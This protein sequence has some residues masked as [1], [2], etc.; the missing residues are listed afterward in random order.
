VLRVADIVSVHVSGT[1]QNVNLIGAEQFAEMKKDAILINL[2]RGYVVDIDALAEN[3]RS[4]KLKGAA[5]DVFPVEPDSGEM[6]QSPL[7]GLPNTVLTPHIAGSTQEAQKEISGFV[8][9]KMINYL[10]RGDTRLSVNFPHTELSQQSNSHRILHIHKNIAGVIAGISQV[11]AANNFNITGETLRTAQELGYAVFDVD[12]KITDK[13]AKDLRAVPG[14][15]K[16]RIL[17]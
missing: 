7:Q 9:N 8:S 4:G 3:L 6:F 11:L 10:T 16:V 2:S 1:P 5:I 12:G 17:Y 13:I 15:I 14:T